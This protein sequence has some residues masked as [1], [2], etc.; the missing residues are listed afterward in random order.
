MFNKLRL[1]RIY[2]KTIRE[3]QEELTKN[4]RLERDLV[5]RLYTIVNIDPKLVEQYYPE[6]VSG[7]VINDYVVKVDRYMRAKGLGELVA[8]REVQQLDKFNVRVV[9]GFSLFDTAK[10]AN[11]LI[12][13]TIFLLSAAIT[14]L[15]IW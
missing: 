10:I 8:I 12:L 9:M 2:R 3:C 14:A 13:L 6:D 5:Y 15:A 11:R 4:F 1:F 7:P